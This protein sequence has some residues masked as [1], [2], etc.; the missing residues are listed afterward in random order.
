[1]EYHRRECLERAA[2]LLVE[3]DWTIER[4]GSE[5]GYAAA[6]NF[7]YAFRRRLG[8]TPAEYR[9]THA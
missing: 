3:T 4:I 9:R 2:D 6:S 8:C 5:V 7:V 1:M